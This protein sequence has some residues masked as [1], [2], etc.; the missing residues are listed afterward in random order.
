MENGFRLE[1]NE[2]LDEHLEPR[3]HWYEL[4]ARQV[5]D[6]DELEIY[7]PLGWMRGRFEWS[8]VASH[9]P[10]LVVPIEEEKDNLLVI[11]L[12]PGSR[13]RWPNGERHYS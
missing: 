9:L 7:T 5:R 2:R 6:G 8:R 11:V 1:L 13:C 4:D 12:L 3:G 10:R